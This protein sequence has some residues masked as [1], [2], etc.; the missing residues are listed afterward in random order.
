MESNLGLEIQFSGSKP[1]HQCEDEAEF[2]Y[3]A[4]TNPLGKPLWRNSW[5]CRRPQ[6]IQQNGHGRHLMTTSVKTWICWHVPEQLGAHMDAK[7]QY[8][9]YIHKICIWMLIVL[10]D[11]LKSYQLKLKELHLE[12]KLKIAKFLRKSVQDDWLSMINI[13]FLEKLQWFSGWKKFSRTWKINNFIMEQR[14]TWE[15]KSRFP[16]TVENTMI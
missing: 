5:I 8:Y 6:H 7:T 2:R 12:E 4:F 10:N 11:I 9:I 13:H 15:R 1:C 14:C 3:M 16:S